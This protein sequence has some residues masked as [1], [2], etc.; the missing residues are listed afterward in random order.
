M[1]Q[2][3]FNRQAPRPRRL[4]WSVALTLAAC[5]SLGGTT[6]LAATTIDFD[7]NW[8]SW[9]NGDA[10]FKQ[11]ITEFNATHP[12]I[13]VN[14][15]PDSG[16]DTKLK[17][18][19]AAG[20]PPDVVHF[21][22]AS[23]IEYAAAG[24]LEPLDDLYKS[25]NFEHAFYPADTA[26]DTWH[27]HY[28]GVPGYT[29]VRG[30]Y[31]NAD[32]MA[33]IGLD[34]EHAPTTMDGLLELG[35]KGLKQDASGKVTRIG[36]L[37]WNDSYTTTGWFWTFGGNIYD[38]A[39][40]KPTLTDPGN[41]AA[42]EWMQDWARRFPLNAL[43]L[44]AKGSGSTGQRELLAGTIVATTGADNFGANIKQYAP[45]LNYRTGEVPH[46]PGGRNGTWGGG[47]GYIV[48]KGAK[49]VREAEV[50]LQWLATEGQKIL[51]EDMDQFPTNLVEADWA[52]RQ[53]QPTDPRLPLF[54]QM[55]ERNPR[56]PLWSKVLSLLSSAQGQVLSLKANPRDVLQG[57]QTQ[58]IPLYQELK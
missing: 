40:G 48:P 58:A 53:L 43:S 54:N 52:K 10:A 25:A 56:P 20:D 46:P 35:Q 38:P 55:G 19:I 31:W 13:Q 44:Q 4:A 11:M 45:E 50:F 23:V 24:L 30:L 15:H 28:W 57:V 21:E 18:E 34:P 47:I 14:G 5:G 16:R 39:T 26:E 33:E 41:V 22:N 2:M 29:N 42:W 27:G 49:H 12:D 17:A 36:F 9:P 6:A 1:T 37:P 51:F 3:T 8:Y 32:A 7:Y